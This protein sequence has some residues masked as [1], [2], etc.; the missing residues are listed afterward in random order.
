[1]I[2]LFVIMVGIMIVVTVMG[3]CFTLGLFRLIADT[4]PMPFLLGL[5]PAFFVRPL[6]LLFAAF[7]ILVGSIPVPIPFLLGP[8]LL[9]INL[10]LLCLLRLV[11]GLRL[12]VLLLGLG[13][14]RLKLLP[15]TDMLVY[16]FLSSRLPVSK[17]LMRLKLFLPSVQLFLIVRFYTLGLFNTFSRHKSSSPVHISVVRRRLATFVMVWFVMLVIRV[18]VF[19]P[20]MGRVLAFRFFGNDIMAKSPGVLAGFL[21]TPQPLILSLRCSLVLI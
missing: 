11:L 16:F 13:N 6:L 5:T 14:L 19:F 18:M 4:L 7:L 20:I 8:A 10:F 3:W 12:L 9:R 21:I 1:M 2:R 17:V 15:P